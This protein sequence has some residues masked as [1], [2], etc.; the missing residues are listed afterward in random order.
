MYKWPSLRKKSTDVQK[1]STDVYE[2]NDSA[3][4]A[5][6]EIQPL[7]VLCAVQTHMEMLIM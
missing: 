1:F 3:V 2:F 6:W 4:V 7:F 5:V